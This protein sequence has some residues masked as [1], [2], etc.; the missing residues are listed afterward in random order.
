MANR[1]FDTPIYQCWWESNFEKDLTVLKMSWLQEHLYRRLI[2][3][4]FV[5]DTQPFLPDDNDVLWILAGAESKDMWMR[6]K[7]LIL[8][9][10]DTFID[11]V[12]GKSLLRHRRVE[13]DWNQINAEKR[14]KS[15]R[16][17]RN[18]QKGGLAKATKAL[19]KASKV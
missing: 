7:E 13:L 9:K 4:M 8:S 12:S 19:A 3:K 18:G 10:F 16:Q 6:E 2:Q 17:K 5:C 14:E 1:H 15:E 11:E